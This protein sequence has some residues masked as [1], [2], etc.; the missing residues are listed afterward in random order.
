[1]AKLYFGVMIFAVLNIV[2]SY[3]LS[4]YEYKKKRNEK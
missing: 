3:S 1:M 4:D 2:C